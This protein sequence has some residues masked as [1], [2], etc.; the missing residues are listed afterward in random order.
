MHPTREDVSERR[1]LDATLIEE[2]DGSNIYILYPFDATDRE[3]KTA[4]IRCADSD[5]LQLADHQ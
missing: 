1:E 2:S 5:L 3:L 4:W